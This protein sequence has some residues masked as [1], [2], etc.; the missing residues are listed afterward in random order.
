MPAEPRP[1]NVRKTVILGGILIAFFVYTYFIREVPGTAN[2]VF[3][4]QTMGTTYEVKI[5]GS[6]LSAGEL[7][8]LGDDM[9]ALLQDLNRQMSTWLPDSEISRF[10]QA[11]ANVPVT[12]SPDF[13]EVVSNALE[14][15]A[16]T[17]GA[18]DPSLGPVINLW[19][20]GEDGSIVEMPHDEAIADA[21][22]RCGMHHVSLTDDGS[23][24]KTVNGLQINLSAIAKGYGADLV[25]GLLVMKGLEDHYVEIG[26]EVVVR[27]T[28]L[29]GDPWRIGIE[30]PDPSLAP[31]SDLV[32]V[33]HLVDRAVAT[34]GDYRNFRVDR[35]GG[36]RSHIIDPATGAPV[37]HD[38][39]SVSVIAPTCTT[40]DGIATAVMVMGPD[41]GLAWLE[42]RGLVEGL[43]VVR[44]EQGALEQVQTSGLG[45]YLGPE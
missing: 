37:S 16:D 36:R 8:A 1:L 31:G 38:L 40:A 3:R 7:Q 27:G 45:A 29:T 25:S 17:N 4:G 9:D 24:V 43:L 28:N 21:L 2:P 11:P 13:K 44:T 22:S 19:G 39:V 33:V 23:L 20:F 26:G 6:T 32:G 42:A 15:H 14:L 30:R 5:V 18:F 35:T 34:S 12:I 41:R 10:N